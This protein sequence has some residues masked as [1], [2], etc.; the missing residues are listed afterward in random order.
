MN[1]ITKSDIVRVIN[2]YQNLK[3]DF[4][5]ITDKEISKIYKMVR[6]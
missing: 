3:N 5:N 2:A 4:V 6:K 1:K